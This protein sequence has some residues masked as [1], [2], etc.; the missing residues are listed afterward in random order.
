MTTITRGLA[1]AA[2]LAGAAV[3]FAGPAAADP[4]E[5]PYTATML[6]AGASGKQ[7]GSTTIWTLSPCGQDCTH[8]QTG[9]PGFDLHRQ[10]ATWTGAE[11][12]TT[13][14]LDDNTLVLTFQYANGNPPVVIGLTKTA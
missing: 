14:T 11:G 5:G 4:A 9:G 10:G 6:D 2:I 8:V 1:A 12:D 3:G 13:R 7:I